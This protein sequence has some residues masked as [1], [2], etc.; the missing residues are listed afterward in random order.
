M[1]TTKEPAKIQAIVIQGL[2]FH[3]LFCRQPPR[4]AGPRTLSLS[5]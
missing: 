5:V 3:R 1:L 2:Y 4:F